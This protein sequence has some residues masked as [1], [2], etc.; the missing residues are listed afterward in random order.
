MGITK[1]CFVH[2]A[3]LIKN[4][5]VNFDNCSIVELG[6]QTVH[7]DDKNFLNEWS[8]SCGISNNFVK[9]MHADITGYEM[10]T[11]LGQ[12]Y[13]CIDLDDLN[14]RV[15]PFLCDLDT[16]T[17]PKDLLSSANI[18]TNYGT[19]EHLFNQVNAFKI[20]HDIAK[21]WAAMIHVVPMTR[22]NH[23]LV[24][25]NPIFFT[26]LANANHYKVVSIFTSKDLQNNILQDL[27]PY[28]GQMISDH[29]YIHA[30]L[31]KTSNTEFKIPKQI[32][33]NGRMA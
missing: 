29:E 20:M 21:P 9:Y 13:H 2:Y 25:Y 5:L 32:F 22:F 17:C 8:H 31:L 15:K 1:E 30:I 26:S 10:H 16:T 6:S 28:N 23:G 7:F 18:V 14:G 24:N 3:T 11:M 12:K 33:S 27:I 19:T 4:S